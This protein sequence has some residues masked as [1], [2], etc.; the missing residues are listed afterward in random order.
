MLAQGERSPS[1]RQWLSVALLAL[2]IFVGDYGLVFW[3]EQR[4]LS[5]LAAVMLATIALFMALFE[6]T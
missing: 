2:L 3:A 4:V 6:I 5:G 1:A